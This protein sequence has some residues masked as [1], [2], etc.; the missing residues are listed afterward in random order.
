MATK[1]SYVGNQHEGSNTAGL[2][3]TLSDIGITKNESST[4]Q[5]L[6]LGEYFK[7][8]EKSVGGSPTHKS[9]SNN[10][11]TSKLQQAAQIKEDAPINWVVFHAQRW[12]W[13]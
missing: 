4:F 10:V 2:P 5:K 9:T 11:V 1:G 13:H 7:G 12:A 6:T 8:M 3:K